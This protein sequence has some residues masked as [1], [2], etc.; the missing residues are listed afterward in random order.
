MKFLIH[1]IQTAKADSAGYLL[2]KYAKCMDED[3]TAEVSFAEDPTCRGDQY[4]ILVDGDHVSVYANTQVG[5]QS[6]V[7]YLLRHQQDGVDNRNVPMASEFRAVYFAAHFFNYYHEAPVGEICEYL[8]SLALW[9]Q[10]ALCVWFDMHHFFSIAD[11]D[12]QMMIERIRRMFAKAKELGMKTALLHLANEYYK[13]APHEILAENTTEGGRYTATPC[14]FFGTELCPSKQEGED[15][16][17][18]SFDELL[19]CFDDIGLDYVMLWPYDQGGCTC[20]DC[21]PWGGNGF[22]KLSKKKAAIAKRRFPDIGI[23]FSCWRFDAFACGEWDAALKAIQDDGDWIDCLMVD[24]HA[25]LPQNLADCSKPIVSFPEISMCYATPWGGFGCNPYPYHLSHQFRKTALMCQGGALYS[26]GI[27]EDI[28]KAVSLELMRDAFLDPAQIVREYCSYHFSAKYADAMTD[29]VLRMERTLPRRTLVG[30]MIHCDYPSGK[31]DKPHTYVIDN[32]GDVEAIAR[33]MRVIDQQ[34]PEKI[35]ANWRYRQIYIRAIGDMELLRHN[36]VPG[37]ETD[38]LYA[39]LTK[40]YHAENACY[41]V[42]P[43]TRESI[44]NNRGNGNGV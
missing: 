36:G 22:F 19:S 13:G 29:I 26:E 8:E 6:A 21:Y 28:N 2:C 5:F 25:P 39:E 33:D 4:R 16:L 27:F 7:G 10:N 15:R 24:I 14:G 34:L 35:K 44:M 18:S 42:A 1:D 20:E 23:I 37:E 31:P 38:A 32:S 40:L 12:A 41:F 11:S 3:G 17:L 43:I 30:G 9:G